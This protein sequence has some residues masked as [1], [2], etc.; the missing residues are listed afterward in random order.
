MKHKSGG[1]C[2]DG[3]PG[4]TRK[5]PLIHDICAHHEQ[6]RGKCNE[7]PRCPVCD[8]AALKT[9]LDQSEMM[10][11]KTTVDLAT[12]EPTMSKTDRF[13][14]CAYPWGKQVEVSE[15]L[16]EA[17]ARFGSAFHEVM[18]LIISKGLTDGLKSYSH[19]PIAWWRKIAARW[20]DDPKSPD[21]DAEAL[22]DRVLNA[23]PV[24]LKWLAGENPWRIDFRNWGIATELALAY[25]IETETTRLCSNP[26]ER[27]E[28]VDRKENELPG[29]ADILGIGI[30]EKTKT[31]KKKDDFNHNTVL[32]I[33]HKS[34]WDVGSPRESSQLKSLALAACR[35]YNVDRAIIAFLHAP[36]DMAATVYAD[37]LDADDLRTHADELKTANARRGDGSMTPGDH[38]KWCQAFTI[39][40][41]NAGALLELRLKNQLQT[42]EDVGAAHQRLKEYERRFLD[43]QSLVD[44]EIRNWIKAHGAAIRPD[45]SAVDFV[46]RSFTNLSQ[47]SIIRAL[48]KLKGGKEI[49]RLKKLGAIEQGVRK[50]LRVVK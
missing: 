38:C 19:K 24:L 8:S 9:A 46:E 16:V 49:E 36:R 1:N 7:C 23:A 15:G 31:G 32:V 50:E 27:H 34:G 45:G 13:L 3:I 18:A 10:M 22:R 14:A 44:G 33:D 30:D 29:T 4:T 6:P 48:G 42:A 37:T 39:C 28:Y 20:S 35:L 17:P 25:D 40:P 12:I 26:N 11:I 5:N 41:T 43:L 2:W 21:I 47:A